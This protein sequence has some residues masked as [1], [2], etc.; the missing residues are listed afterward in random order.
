MIIQRDSFA[1]IASVMLAVFPSALFAQIHFTATLNGAQQIPEIV[2][3]ATGTGSFELSEDF[4]ELRYF[5]SYQGMSAGGVV[6]FFHTGEPGVNGTAVKSIATPASASGTFNGIWKSTDSEPLTKALAESLLTGR[7]YIELQDSKNGSGEIRGQLTLATSLHFEANYSGAQENPSVSSPGGGTGVFILNST[8]TEIDYRITY[9]GLTGALT[10]EGEIHT[11]AVATDGPTI[12]TIAGPGTPASA[13]IKGSWKATDSQP[14][15]AA[16]VDSMIAGKM[17]SNFSTAAHSAGEIRGQLVLQGGIGFMA[18]L[19]SSQENPPT[20]TGASGTG[21]FVLDEA[22]NLLAYHLTYIGLASGLQPSGQILVGSVGQNGNVVKTLVSNGDMSEETISGTWA[23]ADMNEEFNPAIAESLL[24]GELYVDFHTAD[25]SNKIRGQLNLTTGIGFT[26]QLS[27]KQVVPTV[28]MSNGS[29]TASVVLSPDRQSISYSLTYL[30]LDEGISESGGHFHTGAK[31]LN[32]GLVKVIVSPN[33][34]IAMSINGVWSTSDAG[35]Q[36]LSSALADS[37]VVG[38]IYINLH[39]DAYIGG[40]IRGQVSYGLV[41]ITSVPELHSTLP[42]EFILKQNYPNPFNPTTTIR[43][44]ISQTSFV[45]LKVF[46]VLG[47]EVKSLVREQKP[48]GS[49]DVQFDASQLSSGVYFFQLRAG[50]FISVKKMIF[51]K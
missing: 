40:E 50:S 38:D 33:S 9:R 39:T 46:D 26:S 14:L 23:A 24:T 25:S 35:M 28:V 49:Y 5:A 2:T 15:T 45:T 20:L 16:L 18:S 37:F 29:G 36:P 3:P 42:G 7:V 11:G 19:D 30:D 32:G 6:G 47:R 51:E 43:F 48:A 12:K 41:L 8:R 10:S 34:P 4:T 13:T 31:G 27:A 17:Y 44:T 1:L 21:S 22:H